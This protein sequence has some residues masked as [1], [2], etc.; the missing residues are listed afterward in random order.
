L[1]GLIAGL[2]VPE[3]LD[4]WRVF[5]FGR[6]QLKLFVHQFVRFGVTAAAKKVRKLGKAGNR[7]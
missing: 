5:D 7:R 2:K 6:R 1:F 4:R 3:G